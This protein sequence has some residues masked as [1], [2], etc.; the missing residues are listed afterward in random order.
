MQDT[1]QR[2]DRWLAENRPDYYAKLNPGLTDDELTALEQQLG[3]TLPEALKTLLRWRNGQAPGNR[4]SFYYNY[5][6]MDAED[7]AETI[8]THNDL[9][10]SGDYKRAN[11]WSPRWIPFLDNGAGDTY[12][13]D[14]EGS[15]GGAQGQVLEFN[16]DYESRRI[17]ADNLESWLE[18]VSQGLEQGLLEY[19][20]YGMEPVDDRFDELRAEMNPGY[21]L[22]K[23]A[24]K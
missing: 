20:E 19:D 18:T 24:G 10:A 2:L 22:D 1:V 14:T 8:K 15:F 23:Y 17:H 16:H 9:L 11:W 5:T 6:L 7:I 13:V 21:P 12:C 4:K 3:N